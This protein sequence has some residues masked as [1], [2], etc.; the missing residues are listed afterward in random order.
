MLALILS[1]PLAVRCGLLG[2]LGL[3]LGSLINWGIYQLAWDTRAISPWSKPPPEAP[4]RS[5]WDRL[6]V[7][8]WFGLWRETPLWGRGFWIRPL[9][10]ELAVGIGLAGLYWLEVQGWLVPQGPRFD[11]A[12]L[13]TQAM[14]HQQF[15]SAAM[16]ISLM[17]VATFI[18]F[19]E[20]TIPDWITLPGTLAGLLLAALWPNSLP[21]ILVFGPPPL[22][23]TRPSPLWLTAPNAWPAWLNGGEGLLLGLGFF[24]GWCYGVLPKS[25]ITRRGWNK[26]LVYLWA[27]TFRNPTWWVVPLIALFGT[28]LIMAGWLIGGAT[29]MALLTA[30]AGMALGGALVWAVRIIGSSAMR[31]EAMGFGDV[32]LMAMIGAYVGWQGALMTF[33]IAPFAALFIALAQWLFT[34]RKD[35]AFGPYLCAGALYL[36]LRWPA[37]WG[38]VAGVFMLGWLIPAILVGCL[39]LMWGMLLGMR[40]LR[41]SFTPPEPLP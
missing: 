28:P 14:L 19:D 17:L 4:P 20:K 12:D 23:D 22:F 26:A 25:W 11:L 24:W 39:I 5:W 3:V 36:L 8:G 38:N 10:I 29:W 9:L 7:V 32:T 16:L 34:R 31:Q 2:L 35:I 6:P 41:E 30:L 33:F 18:D 13:A 40:M 1:I 37:V 15:I 21:Q 27:S